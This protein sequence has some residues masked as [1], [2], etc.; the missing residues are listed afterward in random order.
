MPF[1]TLALS[2]FLALPVLADPVRPYVVA[3]NTPSGLPADVDKMV[4]DAGGTI[5]ERIPEIAGIGVLSSNP[6]FASA[7]SA[8][9]SVKAADLATT[10]SLFPQ[11]DANLTGG[12]STN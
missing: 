6:N 10:T 8:N 4:A 1:K 12:S 3:F 9:S 5:V 7:M 11:L 2:L